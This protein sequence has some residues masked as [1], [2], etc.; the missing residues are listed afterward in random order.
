METK[1]PTEQVHKQYPVHSGKPLQ[2]SLFSTKPI[3]PRKSN[4]WVGLERSKGRVLTS[5]DSWQ[6]EVGLCF[7]LGTELKVAF[8]L[9]NH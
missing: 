9:V 1:L 2:R 7:L 8:P 4:R 3:F 6:C 5:C